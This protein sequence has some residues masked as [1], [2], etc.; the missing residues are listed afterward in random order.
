MLHSH[1]ENE[2]SGEWECR[3]KINSIMASNRHIQNRKSTSSAHYD[4]RNA[5]SDRYRSCCSHQRKVMKALWFALLFGSLLSLAICF[6]SDHVTISKAKQKEKIGSRSPFHRITNV[7]TSQQTSF[8]PDVFVLSLS[9]TSEPPPRSNLARDATNSNRKTTRKSNKITVQ[10]I[11]KDGRE[12]PL[13]TIE[14]RRRKHEWAERYTSQEGLREAFG[15]N[16][17][18]WWGDLDAKTARRLYKRLLFPTALSELVLELGDEIIR[19]EELAPLAYEAR[20][21]AKMY[22]RERCRVPSRVG[23]YLFD[24]FRQWRKYGRFQPNGVSYEQ[25]WIR[26]Y[27]ENGKHNKTGDEWEYLFGT[28]NTDD[29]DDIDLNDII[30]EIDDAVTEEEIIKRTCQKIFEKSCTTN[31]AIDRFFL[32]EYIVNGT[33]SGNRISD[34]GSKD[35]IENHFDDENDSVDET[36]D[37]IGA[38]KRRGKRWRKKKRKDQHNDLL[39]ARITA[40]LERD[41]R[42]LLEP[43]PSSHAEGD[44]IDDGHCD[45]LRSNIVDVDLSANEGNLSSRRM[46]P[47]EYHSL[48]LFAKA[49]KHSQEQ[50]GKDHDLDDSSK[51]LGSKNRRLDNKIKRISVVSREKISDEKTT[52][53]QE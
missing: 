32:K 42:K 18:K 40:T 47:R 41:V 16:R 13:R 20:R 17:N 10:A 22:A 37:K 35:I 38:E 26:Y 9:S 33:N 25:L 48:K 44:P 3:N 45:E 31:E 43:P 2:A 28:T 36:E 51:A 30:D 49:R 5:A 53:D 21:A 46:T 12:L 1:S 52:H 14:Y 29:D 4:Y 34:I 23:A 6:P 27:E 11:D 50:L 24:G 8:L 39:L 19:P 15:S 7:P